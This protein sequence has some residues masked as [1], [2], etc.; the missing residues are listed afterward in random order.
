M[1]SLPFGVFEVSGDLR[2]TINL[3]NFLPDDDSSF[4]NLGV[5]DDLNSK[6]HGTIRIL[7]TSI[8]VCGF[9]IIPN[10]F[11]ASACR[12]DITNSSGVAVSRTLT[13][14]SLTTYGGTTFSSLGSGTSNS[15]QS[16]TSNLV[17]ASDKLLLIRINTTATSDHI[18]GGYIKLI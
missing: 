9:F 11:T 5:E 1:K 14:E 7:N 17:G 15:E 8:E 18:R 2:M 6:I 13:F 10:G 12:I 4:Y 3:S 16:F